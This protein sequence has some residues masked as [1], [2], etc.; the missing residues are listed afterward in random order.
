MA[1]V[2][3]VARIAGMR[4]LCNSV[5]KREGKKALGSSRFVCL[6]NTK[7]DLKGDVRVKI[8]I[9]WFRTGTSGGLFSALKWTS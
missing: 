6:N 2:K 1:L 9:L 5:R 4:N 3:H 8:L 7:M